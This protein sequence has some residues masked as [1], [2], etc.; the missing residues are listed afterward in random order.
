MKKN[1]IQIGLLLITVFVA[2]SGC[3]STPVQENSAAEEAVKSKKTQEAAAPVPVIEA[4][5][6]WQYKGFGE[7]EPDTAKQVLD[8]LNSTENKLNSCFVPFGDKIVCGGTGSN[9]DQ[10]LSNLESNFN[11]N[12]S[13]YEALPENDDI[14]LVLDDQ[15][16]VKVNP[17]YLNLEYPYLEVKIYSK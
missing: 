1:F 3:A 6:D 14:V 12:L 9:P 8:L 10:A 15:Y 5:E 2:F 16:W 4:F 13:W 17:E 7:A 11:K